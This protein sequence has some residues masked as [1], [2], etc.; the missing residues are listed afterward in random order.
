M[1]KRINNQKGSRTAW[2]LDRSPMKSMLLSALVL[3][4][5]S[6][7]VFSQEVLYTKPAWKFGLAAGA[8][9]NMYT[10][11]THELST[12]F[13]PP[14]VFHKGSGLGLFL[15]PHWEYHQSASLLG[16]MLQAGYDNRQG[17]F[18]TVESP[19]NCP[20]DLESDLSYI[21]IEPSLRLAPF[22][23]S[24]YLYAG[25]RLAFNFQETF[26]FK[27][28]PNPDFPNEI[29]TPDVFGYMSHMKK[30]L[31]SMQIGAGYDIALSNE[32]NRVQ[33]YLSPFIAYHPYFGQHPRSIETWSVSTIR[34]GAVL[35][36]GAG[37]KIQEMR[38]PERLTSIVQQA[39]KEGTVVFTVNSP[40]NIVTTRR[41]RETF[42]VSNFVFFDKESTQIPD[43]YVLLKKS[44]V[45]D[46][47]E[48]QL[49]VFRPKTLSGRSDRQMI[50]YYNVLN[51]LGDRMVKNPSST[52]RLTGS[53]VEGID[54]ATAMAESIKKYLVDVF[55]VK[56]SRIT[57]EGRISPRK[58]SLQP[59]GTNELDLLLEED[60]R[61]SIWS[62]TPDLMMQFQT[63]KNAPMKS[64]VFVNS[65]VAPIS[66]YVTFNVAGATEVLSSWTLELKDQSGAIQK[67][68]PF[69]DEKVSIPGKNILGTKL[70]GNYMATMYGQTKKGNRIVKEQ[71]FPMSLWTPSQSEQGLRYS[72]VFEIGESSAISVY[73]N[74][75]R[76]V[77]TPGIPQNGTVIIHG[78][79]DVVG[80]E[81]NNLAL[82]L[83]R[84][85]EVKSIM[86]E[87]ISKTGRKDVKFEVYGFGEDETL[88][89]FLNEKPEERFYNRTVIIDIIPQS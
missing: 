78:Y 82:S 6:T 57:T 48:D 26:T 72:L 38:E 76:E 41:V 81:E 55:G 61:V 24:F 11:S 59:G 18:K 3:I 74:Y 40:E 51:I 65:Q 80:S 4:G 70:K 46:F 49:E 9:Y 64:V 23:S 87:A 77:V 69:T 30:A 47:K 86:Q 39:E 83:A 66:S 13:K 29:P 50:V 10:G 20:A 32:R 42:P 62:D 7:T 2:S 52:I 17:D 89:P 53:S 75:I 28:G 84:A 58:A 8:N 44:Q 56:E 14:I 37:T 15:A 67:Y 34:V 45:P 1:N 5:I 79:T 85:N 36:L 68:G 27:L 33:A 12:T 73:N 31:L 25:P 21:T 22:K 60:R 19:C 43:R 88:S 63:G 16:F 71:N 54:N 35:K